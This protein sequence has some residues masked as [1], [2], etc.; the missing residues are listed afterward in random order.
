M[1]EAALLLAFAI[2]ATWGDDRPPLSDAE[3]LPPLPLLEYEQRFLQNDIKELSDL[4]EAYPTSPHA[5][6]WHAARC[7]LI[8]LQRWYYVA[9][10]CRCPQQGEDGRRRDLRE[11]RDI[12]PWHYYHGA[13]PSSTHFLARHRP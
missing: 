3:R 9:Y 1:N 5:G 2:M 8:P 13:A 7:E 11:L 4:L 12:S 6:R 10:W